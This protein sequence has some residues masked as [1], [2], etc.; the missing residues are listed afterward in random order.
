MATV[1]WIRASKVLGTETA[2]MQTLQL[3]AWTIAQIGTTLGLI[4]LAVLTY[5]KRFDLFIYLKK[6]DRK[7]ES[8][9]GLK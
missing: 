5:T 9:D 6:M 1:L 7:G 8:G 3:Y 4:I 2:L